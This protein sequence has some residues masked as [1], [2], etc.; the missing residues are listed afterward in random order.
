[1]NAV[2]NC[3]WFV[4]GGFLPGLL[5]IIY[6]LIVCVTVVG[7]P[8]GVDAMRIGVDMFMPF[9]RTLVINKERSSTGYIVVNAIW[10]ILLGWIM[11]IFHILLGVILI[12]TI[13]GIP[14]GLQHF[15]MIPQSASPF[16]YDLVPTGRQTKNKKEKQ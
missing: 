11:V 13:L 2:E 1:M 3:L 15:R 16:N 4:F 10:L 7:I 8:M 5:L 6:G 9:G 12:A 14:L